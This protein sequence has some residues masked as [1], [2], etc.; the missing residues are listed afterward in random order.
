MHH[1]TEYITGGNAKRFV[2]RR[3]RPDT[4]PLADV[5][6]DAG[7]ALRHGPKPLRHGLRVLG[8]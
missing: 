6:D 3:W 4:E 1:E 8:R 7:S 5:R 2:T